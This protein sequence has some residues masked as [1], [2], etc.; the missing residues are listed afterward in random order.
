MN[1]SWPENASL[2]LITTLIGGLDQRQ[3]I[4]ATAGTPCIVDSEILECL[5]VG[6]LNPPGTEQHRAAQI[7]K[8]TEHGANYIYLG[9]ADN[10]FKRRRRGES[11][12]VSPPPA[13]SPPHHGR[14]ASIAQHPGVCTLE[15][16]R[17]EGAEISPQFPLR[18][19]AGDKRKADQPF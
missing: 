13:C 3:L 1:N 12:M 19:V 2:G 15:G 11:R 10:F 18:I 14:G 5:I 6:L 8:D 7:P 17:G 4:A 16:C 9:R